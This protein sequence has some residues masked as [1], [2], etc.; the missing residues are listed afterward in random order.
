MPAIHVCMRAHTLIIISGE[1]LRKTPDTSALY[2]RVYTYK[3]ICLQHSTYTDTYAYKHTQTLMMEGCTE[4]YHRFLVTP[5]F[6]FF[7]SMQSFTEQCPYYQQ[8]VSSYSGVLD[9]TQSP[10][11]PVT[12]TNPSL[13]TLPHTHTPTPSNSASVSFLPAFVDLL[14]QLTHLFPCHLDCRSLLPWPFTYPHSERRIKA[15]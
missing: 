3:H 14:L 10:R 1:Q 9:N 8:I 11:L 4:L 6:V 2:T 13:T 7:A 5:E 12:P 15:Q